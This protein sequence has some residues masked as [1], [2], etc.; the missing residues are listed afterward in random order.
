MELYSIYALVFDYFNS[1]RCFWNVS[2]LLHYISNIFAFNVEQL[3]IVWK[4]QE[5][6]WFPWF[7]FMATKIEM[8]DQ[9][10]IMVTIQ[11]FIQ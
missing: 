2:T 4:C 8:V 7:C 11:S 3:S 10:Y 9:C 5:S 6:V 1:I